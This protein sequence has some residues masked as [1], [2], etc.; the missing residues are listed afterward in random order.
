MSGTA[1]T[2][3]A[4]RSANSIRHWRLSWVALALTV[5]LGSQPL[6]T[7]PAAAVEVVAGFIKLSTTVVSMETYQ[8]GPFLTLSVPGC[9]RRVNVQLWDGAEWQFVGRR[10]T[11]TR[12]LS[13]GPADQCIETRALL[14]VGELITGS[15]TKDV[16]PDG[17]YLVRF[18]SPPESASFGVGSRDAFGEWHYPRVDI[19]AA[20]SEPLAVTVTPTM[21]QLSGHPFDEWIIVGSV[22]PPRST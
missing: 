17:A 18:V 5:I 9:G 1:E 8:W 13:L 14:N 7:A 16:V 15:V 10:A 2:Q 22:P 6:A 20:I 19:G 11:P 21:P 3:R 4:R 12:D